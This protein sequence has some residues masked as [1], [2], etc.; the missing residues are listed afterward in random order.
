LN[1]ISIPAWLQATPLA[2]LL[3]VFLLVPILTVIVVSFW[4]YDQ[5]RLI[6]GFVFDNYIDALTEGGFKVKNPNAATSCS[7]GESFSA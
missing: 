5:T 1:R 3:G 2:L 4:D 7:C 6:P